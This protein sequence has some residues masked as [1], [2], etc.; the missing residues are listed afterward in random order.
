MFKSSS[1]Y[2]FSHAFGLNQ[3][4]VHVLLMLMTEFDKGCPTSDI[5][6]IGRHAQKSLYS[7]EG[8]AHVKRFRMVVMV[9]GGDV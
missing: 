8:Q 9:G 2:F 7:P 6:A 5:I 1:V 3:S 4:R